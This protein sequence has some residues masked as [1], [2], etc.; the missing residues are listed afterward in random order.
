MGPVR[1]RYPAFLDAL[2]P[3]LLVREHQVKEFG[4]DHDFVGIN[5]PGHQI[6]LASARGVDPSS[7]SPDPHGVPEPTRHRSSPVD[8]IGNSIGGNDCANVGCYCCV[9]SRNAG[10]FHTLSAE[11]NSTH[12][13]MS[14]STSSDSKALSGCWL[15]AATYLGPLDPGS[16]PAKA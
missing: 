5:M 7:L 11:P 12:Y 9:C 15:N 4:R 10:I 1:S 2:G 8:A 3:D 6:V 16:G 13:C 14:F